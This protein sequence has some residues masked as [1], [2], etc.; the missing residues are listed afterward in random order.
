MCE[1]SP[2]I[3]NNDEVEQS[4]ALGFLR[5][6]VQ[7]RL[8]DLEE[9]EVPHYAPLVLLVIGLHLFD[10]SCLYRCRSG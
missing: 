10:P 8:L 1:K 9:V 3:D 5:L 6:G 7:L 4:V 2:E